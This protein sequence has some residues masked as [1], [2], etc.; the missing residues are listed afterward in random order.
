MCRCKSFFFFFFYSF[1]INSFYLIY[2]YYIII[3]I[4]Y[5]III[6]LLYYKY[7]K[8]SPEKKKKKLYDALNLP[9]WEC[10]PN[11]VIRNSFNN[12]I[13]HNI[14]ERLVGAFDC[15]KKR[16]YYSITEEKASP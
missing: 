15:K 9:F 12:H 13:I 4:L 7:I 5:I 6:L 10:D 8:K 11:C 3:I 2:Y 14:F 16:N 1:F